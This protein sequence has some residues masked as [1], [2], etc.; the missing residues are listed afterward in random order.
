MSQ[1]SLNLSNFEYMSIYSVF[2]PMEVQMH[3]GSETNKQE[4]KFI[5]EAHVPAKLVFFF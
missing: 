2:D 1:T 3:N 4:N 5:F